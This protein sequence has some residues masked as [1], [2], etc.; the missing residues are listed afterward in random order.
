M[1]GHKCGCAHGRRNQPLSR[2]VKTRHAV[3][4]S[5]TFGATTKCASTRCCSRAMP[6]WLWWQQSNTTFRDGN[7]SEP[8]TTMADVDRNRF[9][10]HQRYG[11]PVLQLPVRFTRWVLVVDAN[12]SVGGATGPVRRWATEAFNHR[13]FFP[14][15]KEEGHP[16]T[17]TAVRAPLQQ[18]ARS[19][20]TQTY[21][22]KTKSEKR[23]T[24]ETILWRGGQA[25]QQQ[26]A[27]SC[28]GGCVGHGPHESARGQA[29]LHLHA[30]A[31]VDDLDDGSG[32]R[33]LEHAVGQLQVSM[34][35]AS[36]FRSD[37]ALVLAVI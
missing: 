10:I 33:V 20:A 2:N 36:R 28:L 37:F 5:W 1:S 11:F 9:A 15:N 24:N 29:V 16:A 14:F 32:R 25:R 6:V 8:S 7:F 18:C 3:P 4:T 12:V 30:E 31:E 22:W 27:K 13:L 26:Q 17:D 23:N 21:D 34:L 35:R 19:N